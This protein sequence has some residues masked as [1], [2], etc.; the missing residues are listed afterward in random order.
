MI[1]TTRGHFFLSLVIYL[2]LDLVHSNK[3]MMSHCPDLSFF[4]HFTTGTTGKM[5]IAVDSIPNFS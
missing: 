1:R 3:L 4:G 5:I 2:K